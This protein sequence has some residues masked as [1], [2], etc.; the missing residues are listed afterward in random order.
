MDIIPLAWWSW[1][2]TAVGAGGLLVAGTKP[3]LGW[4]IG[5]FV[6]QPL[7]IAYSIVTA[8]WGF[9][10]SALIYGTVFAR[11][12]WKSLEYERLDDGS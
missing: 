5:L 8:Q 1:I 4:A 2:L 12:L 3:S 9:L 6:A 11:N 10:V 7:W